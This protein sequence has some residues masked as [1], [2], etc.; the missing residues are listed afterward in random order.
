[1]LRSSYPSGSWQHPP[2]AEDRKGLQL[3]REKPRHYV[4]GQVE[5]QSD[6][7]I[8]S[9]SRGSS[10]APADIEKATKAQASKLQ[11]Q[12]QRLEQRRIDPAGV[13]FVRSYTSATDSSLDRPGTASE[14]PEEMDDPLATGDD[15]TSK[16]VTEAQLHSIPLDAAGRQ[17]SLGSVAHVAGECKPCLFINTKMGCQNGT[18]C[19]FCHF[20]HKRQNKLRPCKGKRDRYRQLVARMEQMIECDPDGFDDK[21]LNLPPSI[22]GNHVLKAKLMT[23]MHAHAQ[24]VKAR[25]NREGVPPAEACQLPYGNFLTFEEAVPGAPWLGQ[26]ARP[27]QNT[28]VIL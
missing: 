18:N 20:P 27:G 12:I 26:P 22:A 6:S 13:S 24:L 5:S 10:P 23:K 17:T 21:Q 25:E 1:M 14:E 19:Q 16:Q 28:R 2:D 11:Q 15:I 8:T 9:S 3:A 7:Q 4:W